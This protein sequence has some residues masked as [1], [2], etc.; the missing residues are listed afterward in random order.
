MHGTGDEKL[1]ESGSMESARRG[2]NP[3]I[4]CGRDRIRIT[5]I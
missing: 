1:I 4:W 5:Y 3:A 2:A